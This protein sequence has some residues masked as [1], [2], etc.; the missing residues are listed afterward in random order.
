MANPVLDDV[1][2]RIP[3]AEQRMAEL[4]ELVKVATDAGEDTT[5]YTAEITLLQ[6]RLTNWKNALQSAGYKV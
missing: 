4:Q 6:H 3:E 5:G 2:R 1:A